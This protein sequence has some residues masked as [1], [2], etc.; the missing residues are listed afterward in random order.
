MGYDFA[1]SKYTPSLG[2]SRLQVLISG[3]PKERFFDVKTLHVPTIDGRFF[4]QTQI[5]RHEL[6]PNKA[7][8][9]CL[10]QISLNS[11]QGESMR[12]FSFGGMLKTSLESDDLL[13]ELTSSAPLFKLR[14]DPKVVGGVVADEIMD[15]LAENLSKMAGQENELYSRLAKYDPY[16][17]F[18]ACLVSLQKRADSV[19][20]NL[21]RERYQKVVSE[22]HHAAQTVQKN[23]GW[24][25]R[26]PSLEDLLVEGSG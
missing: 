5:S 13:C 6:E 14:E 24:D 21:R 26:S 8:Q 16:Q 17:V 3:R 11:F 1:P 25:G 4:H 23:D 2:Y 7:Y 9:V 10:G 19:P 20:T 18:L 22:L 15:L 12:A